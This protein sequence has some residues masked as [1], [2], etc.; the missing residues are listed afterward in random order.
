MDMRKWLK[1]PLKVFSAAADTKPTPPDVIIGK[2]APGRQPEEPD[3][4]RTCSSHRAETSGSR[5]TMAGTVFGPQ[6]PVGS[7]DVSDLGTDKPKQVV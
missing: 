3:P 5:A 7:V 6:L 2:G 4:G 1:T